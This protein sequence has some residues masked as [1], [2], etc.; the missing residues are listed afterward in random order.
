MNELF[1]P[2][3]GSPF[4]TMEEVGI[5]QDLMNMPPDFVR[6]ESLAIPA[7]VPETGGRYLF[8]FGPQALD[9]FEANFDL[10]VGG[11]GLARPDEMSQGIENEFLFNPE[12]PFDLAVKNLPSVKANDRAFAE[13]LGE[14]DAFSLTYPE[15]MAAALD[16]AMGNSGAFGFPGSESIDLSGTQFLPEIE[17]IPLLLTD[18]GSINDII[19]QQNL[20]VDEP[21]QFNPGL[22]I[23]GEPIRTGLD[24]EPWGGPPSEPPSK[25][26][27]G[28]L[29]PGDERPRNKK[30][31]WSKFNEQFRT[32]T[33]IGDPMNYGLNP[34][35]TGKRTSRKRK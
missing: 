15:D 18:T 31:W 9:A 24:F 16:D 3:G 11:L 27:G 10:G 5:P 25:R 33:L 28:G 29:L 23:V 1:V 30:P 34:P 12:E 2:K 20:I 35:S 14:S 21:V 17:S 32:G 7:S 6:A 22:N 19:P 8:G 4:G 13:V 26:R